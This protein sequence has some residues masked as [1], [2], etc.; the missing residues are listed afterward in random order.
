MQANWS[1]KTLWAV[2]TVAGLFFA[3]T[4]FAFRGNLHARAI[5]I[6][7]VGFTLVGICS[8]GMYLS[9]F[10]MGKFF[11]RKEVV[12]QTRA[13]FWAIGVDSRFDRYR[14]KTPL[15]QLPNVAT[16][17]NLPAISLSEEVVSPEIS[18]RG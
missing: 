7:L 4:T 16:A 1:L 9:C 2:V 8:V 3:V 18:E 10:L 5:A 6:F 13:G 14:A 12:I 11:T 17:P 15:A